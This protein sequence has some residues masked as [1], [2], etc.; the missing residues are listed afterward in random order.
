MRATPLLFAILALVCSSAMAQATIKKH[1]CFTM[2]QLLWSDV[3]NFTACRDQRSATCVG[4]LPSAVAYMREMRDQGDQVTVL[5]PADQTSAFVQMHSL[6]WNVNMLFFRRFG[7]KAFTGE[8]AL[9]DG[10]STYT[11]LR[12]EDLPSISS[13][14]VLSLGSQ[15]YSYRRIAYVDAATG[16]GFIV[17]QSTLY[18]NAFDWIQS[19]YRAL[20]HLQKDSDLKHVVVVD[21]ESQGAGAQNYTGLLRELQR[22]SPVKIDFL[23]S[24]EGVIDEK[25][26]EINGTWVITSASSTQGRY[27]TS[28]DALTCFDFTVSAA[29]NAILAAS[30]TTKDLNNLPSSLKTSNYYADVTFAQQLADEAVRD[31]P[32]IG[33]T[34]FMPEQASADGL[35]RPCMGGEC[36]QGNMWAD[37]Y[38]WKMD[39]DIAFQNSAAIRGPG[40]PA[41]QVRMSNLYV[42]LP[43]A[44][45]VCTATITGLN[46]WKILNYSIGIDLTPDFKWDGQRLL[47]LSGVRIRFNKD[48]FP[49]RLLSVEVLNKKTDSYEPLDRLKLYTVA[50]PSYECTAL[51]PYSDIVNAAQYEGEVA[52]YVHQDLVIQNVVAAFLT[53]TSTPAKP[54]NINWTTRFINVPSGQKQDTMN[55]IQ[56][57]S[58]CSANTFWEPKVE[59]CLACPDG[60]ESS[61]GSIACH[62][63]KSDDSV[64][65][66]VVP[67][68]VVLA[69]IGVVAAVLVTK[70]T[71]GRDVGAAPKEGR[72]AVLFTDIES[73]TLLWSTVPMSMNSS[74]EVHHF[75]IRREIR[76]HRAYEV[77]TVGD[78]FMIACSSEKIAVTLAMDIQKELQRAVFP[79]CINQVYAAGDNQEKL[80]GIDDDPNAHSEHDPVF[81]G[82]RVRIGIHSGEPTI[83]LDEITKGYD[84]YG[85]MVNVAARVESVAQGGQVCVTNDVIKR[86]PT[87]DGLL[88]R[89]L[90]TVT[91]KGVV[92]MTEIIE[93]LPVE[94]KQ[95]HFVTKLTMITADPET[96]GGEAAG[97]TESIH[98]NESAESSAMSNDLE[99]I[100]NY[101]YMFVTGMLRVFKPEASKSMRS[102]L[103]KAWNIDDVAVGDFAR[104]KDAALERLGRRVALSTAKQMRK[105][106]QQGHAP[107]RQLSMRRG[108]VHHTPRQN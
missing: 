21:Y 12:D 80:D 23:L 16:I 97:D 82:L 106:Q 96:N 58:S 65:A 7:F 87:E 60:L 38:R 24:I 33:Y 48:L 30:H 31:D 55:W 28:V 37:S 108:S 107:E 26:V 76:K 36:A 35:W 72:V 54:Y 105:Q 52:A 41:G 5:F 2:A 73:S 51:P 62:E 63:K 56:T 93:V 99:A 68:V 92:E 43:Y 47:Q 69:I 29:S 88:V 83:V 19:A 81:N 42:T 90:G 89:S 95:R 11:L 50:M 98:S 18:S 66:I 103:L 10:P 49:E 86:L 20:E 40:W 78:S 13:N 25:F 74:L 22:I 94:L 45:R 84:Y 17:L 9:Y 101:N 3:N 64:V 34:T 77:K 1:F 39:V 79:A 8:P 4:G 32:L 61:G 70:G 100:A 71:S 6:N 102:T 53:S 46:V 59:S 27:G 44:N 75:I 104:S 85:P 91:L 14:T 57:R 67:I 15:W